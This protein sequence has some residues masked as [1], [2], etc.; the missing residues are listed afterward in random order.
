M[1]T[2]RS[3]VFGIIKACIALC[4]LLVGGSLAASPAAKAS[5]PI[6]DSSFKCITEMTHVRHFYV[7]NLAG[8]LGGTVKV[9]GSDR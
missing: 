7:D 1:K 3:A 2:I 4:V 5:F 9:A 6:S 8:N